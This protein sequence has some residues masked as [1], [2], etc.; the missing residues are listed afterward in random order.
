MQ[1]QSRT[2]YY[3]FLQSLYKFLDESTDQQS[4]EDR[5]RE[6]MGAS[7]A[8]YMMFTLDKLVRNL[9]RHA[10]EIVNSEV[11]SCM[12]ELHQYEMAAST[13][14]RKRY[15]DNSTYIL[16]G[17]PNENL[18]LVS[19]EGGKLANS[20]PKGGTHVPGVWQES[21]PWDRVPSMGFE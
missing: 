14:V 12:L 15:L 8:S 18:F 16:N 5:C 7:T 1:L 11:C 2:L 10:N 20:P 21:L 9:V 3:D 19:S 4:F 13:I 17:D 6:L